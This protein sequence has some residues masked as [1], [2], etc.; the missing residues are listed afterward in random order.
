MCC[1]GA[2]AIGSISMAEGDD[3]AGEFVRADLL[4]G[5]DGSRTFPN[6]IC[7][8]SGWQNEI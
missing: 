4:E 6:R 2:S 1:G 3:F 5:A 7:K 8:R